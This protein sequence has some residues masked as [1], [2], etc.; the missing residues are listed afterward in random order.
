PQFEDFLMWGFWERAHWLPDGAMYRADWS[1]KPNA[2]V[3]NELL[4]N[5]WWTNENGASDADGKFQARGFK[6]DYNV[7]A[8]YERVEKTITAK[9]GNNGEVV[10]DLD[11]SGLRPGI[12]RPI[13]P[14]R[15]IQM[16]KAQAKRVK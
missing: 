3:W 2:L 9:L 5:E 12:K 14:E 7:T 13:P 15:T 11:V 6:G 1:S 8:R 4:F 10:I 16:K